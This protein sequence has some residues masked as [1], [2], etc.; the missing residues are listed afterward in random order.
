MSR[1]E[2]D[3]RH[4]L[5]MNDDDYVHEEMTGDQ[6]VQSNRTVAVLAC[7]RE[8]GRPFVTY[9][10]L[11]AIVVLFL[12]QIHLAIG[13]KWGGNF[14]AGLLN[15]HPVERHQ[16]GAVTVDDLEKGEWWRLVTSIFVHRDIFQLLIYV[17]IF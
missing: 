10:L 14:R 2:F 3:S 8:G 13:G 17:S 12:A 4:R 16:T 11:A 15:D 6:S 5:M 7:L 9:F 1:S